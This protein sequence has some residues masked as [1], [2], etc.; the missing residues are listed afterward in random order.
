MTRKAPLLN[1]GDTIGLIAPSEIY[2]RER[3]RSKMENLRKLGFNPVVGKAAYSRYS[4][5]AGTDEQRAFDINDMFSNPE[6]KGIMSIS[7]GMAASRVIPHIDFGLIK[8]NP[9]VFIGFSDISVLLNAIYAKT[10]MITFH[11]PMALDKMEGSTFE[12]FRKATMVPGPWEMP[13]NWRPLRK[14]EMKGRI[15]G[16]N[17]TSIRSL[18]GTEYAPDWKGKILF[19][20]E[21]MEY[22]STISTH[23]MHFK[24]AGVFEKISGMIIGKLK[25]CGSTKLEDRGLNANKIVLEFTEEYGFPVIYGFE[26]GHFAR[27]LTLPIGAEAR[28]ETR[29]KKFEILEGAVS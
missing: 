1:E 10:D 18:I 8:S 24:L 25:K 11:G 17:L 12:Y 4:F 23:L 3:L 20:E 16:G 22:P 13:R 5:M 21:L 9:K 6:I 27:N 28:I 19:W 26:S 29:R 14:G 7:G 2:N 15:V